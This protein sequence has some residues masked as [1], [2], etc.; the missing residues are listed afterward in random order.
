MGDGG[1]VLDRHRFVVS[2][3]FPFWT[4]D[5]GCP[6]LIRLYVASHIP[7][8]FPIGWGVAMLIRCV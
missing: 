4:D 3:L 1:T 6:C 2:F 8:M 5:L 7:R